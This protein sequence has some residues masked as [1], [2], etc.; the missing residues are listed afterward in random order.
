M[1]RNFLLEVRY[2]PLIGR[3]S[4][5][6]DWPKF[7][8]LISTFYSYTQEWFH[9][10]LLALLECVTVKLRHDEWE[11]RNLFH[12]TFKSIFIFLQTSP[13]LFFISCETLEYFISRYRNCTFS[14]LSILEHNFFT[15]E[16]PLKL[17]RGEYFSR[18]LMIKIGVLRRKWRFPMINLSNLS[19]IKFWSRTQIT[20]FLFFF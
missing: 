16:I 17:I 5:L 2:C 20:K 15:A 8:P 4:W 1:K 10:L 13:R 3:E 18:R 14:E 7:W 11:S 9:W 6:R 12:Q 19:S